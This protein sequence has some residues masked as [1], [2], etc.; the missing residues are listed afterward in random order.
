MEL[1]ADIKRRDEI[2]FGSFNP[3]MYLLGGIRHFETD[4]ST[5]E[6]LIDEGFADPDERQNDSPSIKEFLEY[7]EDH[8]LITFSGYAVS[9]DRHD[10]RVTIEQIN[11]VID[12]PD[13]LTKFVE[14]FRYAD[15]LNLEYVDGGYNMRAWW[16]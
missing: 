8:D 11:A 12:D 5:I 13:T 15:E 16:D 3:S 2:L 1:N 6:K 9:G 10:Y 14:L 7:T 4:R